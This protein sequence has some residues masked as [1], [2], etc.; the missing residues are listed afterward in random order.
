MF[1]QRVP[2]GV[3]QVVE[4]VNGAIE[5]LAELIFV[6]C[7]IADFRYEIRAARV[8]DDFEVLNPLDAAADAVR[9]FRRAVHAQAHAAQFGN[10]FRLCAVGGDV[11]F[12]V[13]HRRHA[14]GNHVV[15]QPPFVQL[16]KHIQAARRN[17]QQSAEECRRVVGEAEVQPEHGFKGVRPAD[18]RRVERGFPPVGVIM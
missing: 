7:V 11:H 17:V 5:H 1:F 3:H 8:D 10:G 12:A 9:A 18:F 6:P 13:A 14:L 16:I 2:H 15:R 4:V